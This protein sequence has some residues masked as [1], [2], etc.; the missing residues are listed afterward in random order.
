MK[1]GIKGLTK[2]Q[3]DYIYCLPFINQVNDLIT[4]GDQTMKAGLSFQKP[5]LA[6]HDN[7]F[8]FSLTFSI[9]QDNLL[10]KFSRH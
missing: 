5:M 3:Y 4:E 9:S 6:M 8:V 7:C 10:H 1:D 2:I